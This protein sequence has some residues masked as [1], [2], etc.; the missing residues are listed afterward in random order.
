[1]LE[2]DE[3]KP[4][5]NQ[6]ERSLWAMVMMRAIKDLRGSDFQVKQTHHNIISSSAMWWV[7]HNGYYIG[8]FM[9]VCEVLG[10]D[11]KSTREKLIKIT[12]RKRRNGAKT[13]RTTATDQCENG[14]SR[15]GPKPGSARG[16]TPAE[17]DLLLH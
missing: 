11:P 16:V 2:E 4:P 7:K 5:T 6:A 15:E 1:M 12:E 3:L 9:Y 14:G 10:I 17:E 8:S 13:E